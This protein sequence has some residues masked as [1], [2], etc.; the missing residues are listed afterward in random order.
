MSEIAEN[1][2]EAIRKLIEEAKKVKVDNSIIEGIEK[3][4]SE[5]NSTP[6]IPMNPS[7]QWNLM[8]QF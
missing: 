8:S 7:Q 1:I 4:L 5:S 3:Q 6:L 2:R